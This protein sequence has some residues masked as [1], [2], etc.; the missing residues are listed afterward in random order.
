MNTKSRILLTGGR[1][2]VTLDLARRFKQYGYEVYVAESISYHL[3]RYSNS[4]KKSFLVPSPA[5]YKSEYI[6][7]LSSLIKKYKNDRYSCNEGIILIMDFLHPF[8][9]LKAKP[10]YWAMVSS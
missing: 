9:D 6:N 7:E 4:V 8:N 1:A 5:N 3:C 2:P 10:P